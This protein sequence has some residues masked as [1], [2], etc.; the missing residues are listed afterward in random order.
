MKWIFE[1]QLWQQGYA[2][3]AG[4]DESGR[5]A[6]AGPVVAA[7][8]ILAY[9]NYEYNDSKQISKEKRDVFARDIK[10][11][12]LA[13]AVASASPQ[14]ID[15][16]NIL[17]ATHLAS[18]RA[19]AKLSKVPQALVTD[20]LKLKTK[21]EILAPSKADSQSYQVAAASILAKTTRDQIM[22]D[23]AKK[24]PQYRFEDHKGYG[25]SVHLAAIDE[26][27]VTDIHRLSYKPVAQRR[28]F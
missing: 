21:L 6:L 14:E 23:Y 19:I 1:Q 20:Y 16:L 18:H 3:T 7:V 2:L 24:F 12:A 9:G 10:T 25:S 22:T 15:N 27:G 8:V 17:Q 26:F 11:R 4:I 5:G 28:L 13:W